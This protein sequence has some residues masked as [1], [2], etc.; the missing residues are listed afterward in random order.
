MIKLESKSNCM[1]CSACHSICPVSAIEMIEDEEGFKYPIIDYEKCIS[2]GAC[3]R[4]CPEKN[5]DYITKNIPECYAVYHKVDDIRLKASSGGIFWGIAKWILDNKGAVFGVGWN[6]ECHV[7]YFAIENIEKLDLLHGAKY[8]QASVDNYMINVK[9]L[10]EDGRWVLFSGTPCQVAGLKSYLKKDYEKLIC[11]DFVCHGV[12]SYHLLEKYTEYLFPNDKVDTVNFRSKKTGW[13]NYSFEAISCNKKRITDTVNKN[14]YMRAYLS[15][16]ALR[17]SCY[18]CNYKGVGRMS[19]FTI[20]DFWG[21]ENIDPVMDDNKGVSLML[22]HSQCAKKIWKDI[23]SNYIYKNELLEHVIKYNSAIVNRAH[24][25]DTRK[26][27]YK[28]LKKIKS[29]KLK[30]MINKASNNTFL[31]KVVRKLGVIIK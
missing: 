9:H 18:N 21:I 6:D 13:H 25:P 16:I 28:K 31:N 1:G 24:E 15:D 22:L 11:V 19:D 17:P 10:L 30:E 3:V 14:L 7:K 4:I 5:L 12:P 8:V 26:L 29:S 2:C 20:G 23:S 27:F